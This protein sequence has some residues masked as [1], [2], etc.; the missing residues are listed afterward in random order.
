MFRIQAAHSAVQAGPTSAGESRP[1]A[2]GML[3]RGNAQAFADLAPTLLQ[4]DT[5]GGGRTGHMQVW[6]GT[7]QEFSPHRQP[8]NCSDGSSVREDD[9]KTPET[10]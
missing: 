3:R 1:N 10:A 7:E 5:A 4:P 9:T 6:Q 8:S 2:P